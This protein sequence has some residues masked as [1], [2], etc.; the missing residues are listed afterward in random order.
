MEKDRFFQRILE[1]VDWGLPPPPPRISNEQNIQFFLQAEFFWGGGRGFD[2]WPKN[3]EKQPATWVTICGPSWVQRGRRKRSH[4][5][6]MHSVPP[7]MIDPDVQLFN[8][9]GYTHP[10]VKW[11]TFSLTNGYLQMCWVN[12]EREVPVISVLGVILKLCFMTL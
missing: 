5:K 7:R 6:C 3:S 11:M 10:E 9:L 8:N 2:L 1:L 12:L 4:V